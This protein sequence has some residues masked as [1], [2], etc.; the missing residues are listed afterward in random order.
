MFER[1][2][3]GAIKTIMLAQEETRRLAHNF[4]GSQQ[5][6]LGLIGER[7]RATL[8]YRTKQI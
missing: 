4:V 2:A 1:F 3:E 5:I 6:L 8:P 7:G